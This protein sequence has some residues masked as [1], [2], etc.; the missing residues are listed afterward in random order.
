[1]YATPPKKAAKYKVKL[2]V[3]A[4]DKIPLK[5]GIIKPDSPLY[6]L[7]ARSCPVDLQE[8][9]DNSSI[10]VFDAIIIKG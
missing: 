3:K 5:Y 4:A 9:L 8:S 2:I 10:K 6:M 7:I 1:M